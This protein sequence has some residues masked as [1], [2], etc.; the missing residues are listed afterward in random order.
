MKIEILERKLIEVDSKTT[1]SL[2]PGVFDVEDK[3]AKELIAAGHAR[4]PGRNEP[5]PKS[6]EPA[7]GNNP[8]KKEE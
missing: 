6:D 1:L 4:K 8:G 3:V 7:D 2:H 5:E